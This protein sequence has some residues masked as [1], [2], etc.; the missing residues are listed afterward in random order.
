[1]IFFWYRNFSYASISRDLVGRDDNAQ[2]NEAYDGF[3]L[4]N[5]YGSHNNVPIDFHSHLKKFTEAKC[6]S[7]FSKPVLSFVAHNGVNIQNPFRYEI[8]NN[9]YDLNRVEARFP[10]VFHLGSK[11][12]RRA[13]MISLFR[14]SK[15]IIPWSL[16]I[17]SFY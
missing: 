3:T 16:K 6:F 10:S 2:M 7:F 4:V 13:F 1:M 9:I 11:F 5:S 15:D 17:M 14:L 12:S 8:F